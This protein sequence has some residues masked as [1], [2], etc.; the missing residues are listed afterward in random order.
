[1]P[2]S[3]VGYSLHLEIVRCDD[4]RKWKHRS[5]NGDDIWCDVEY[6]AIPN[7]GCR[8]IKAV[9]DH[10]MSTGHPTYCP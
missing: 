4:C 9:R 5:I 8:K 2:L 7:D 3:Q 6:P 1:M 10:I